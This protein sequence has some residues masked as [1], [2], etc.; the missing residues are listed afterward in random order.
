[1]LKCRTE[2]F[3]T[4]AYDYCLVKDN[5]SQLQKN[6]YLTISKIVIQVSNH[7]LPLIKLPSPQ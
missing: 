5:Y 6:G 4:P 3:L 1:M 7:H 2:P